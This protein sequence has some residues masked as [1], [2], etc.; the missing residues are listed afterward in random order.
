M[1][2]AVVAVSASLGALLA[3]TAC[4][5]PERVRERPGETLAPLPPTIPVRRGSTTTSTVVV[6]YVVQRGD[7]LQAIA[8]RVGVPVEDLA[9]ANA[10]VDPNRIA[11]GQ[12]LVVP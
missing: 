8:N 5:S 6:T 10:I 1:R 3:L 7:T 11:E 4:S 2:R 12:V 9:G